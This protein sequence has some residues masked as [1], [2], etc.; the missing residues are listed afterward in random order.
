M[1]ARVQTASYFCD[2]VET[3]TIEAVKSTASLPRTVYLGVPPS[4]GKASKERVLTACRQ[5]GFRFPFAKVTVN[6]KSA[7][8]IK[9]VVD[10]DAAIATCLLQLHQYI[11]QQEYAVVGG[12]SLNAQL[13]PVTGHSLPGSFEQ[14]VKGPVGLP[15]YRHS[16]L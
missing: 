11:P 10:L 12:L 5:A 14:L 13:L 1:I 16:D 7:R 8:P 4:E 2:G 9:H 6:V 3:V 15:W